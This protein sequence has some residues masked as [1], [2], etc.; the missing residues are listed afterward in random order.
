M[1]PTIIHRIPWTTP[2]GYTE[3]SVEFGDEVSYSALATAALAMEQAYLTAHP[4]LAPSTAADPEREPEREYERDREPER[5]DPPR[6]RAQQG[7]RGGYSRPDPGAPECP[8]HRTPMKRN[9]KDNGWF[10]TKRDRDGNYCRETAWD[11]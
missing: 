9:R 6:Y 11:R 5:N 3:A 10:C 8:D 4:E 1:T 7:N 2:Y